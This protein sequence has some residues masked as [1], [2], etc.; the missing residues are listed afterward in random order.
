MLIVITAT[1]CVE[2]EPVHDPITKKIVE[3]G[4]SDP[5]LEDVDRKLVIVYAGSNRVPPDENS[6]HSN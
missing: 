2:L 1:Y 6:R 5:D 4:V 3:R